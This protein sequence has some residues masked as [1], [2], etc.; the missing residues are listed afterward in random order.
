MLPIIIAVLSF[1]LGVLVYFLA[2]WPREKINDEILNLIVDRFLTRSFQAR[3]IAA[4][5]NQPSREIE[6]TLKLLERSGILKKRGKYYQTINPLFFLS[7]SYYTKSLR[8]SIDDEILY[9][10]AQNPFLTNY[11]LVTVYGLVPLTIIFAISV[12]LGIFPEITLFF[13]NYFSY[14]ELNS[15]L[16]FLILMSIVA[17][18]AIDNLIK[19]WAQDRNSVIVGVKSGLTYDIGYATE[20]SGRIR[21]PKLGEI[22]YEISMLQKF[23]NFFSEMPHGDIIIQV[24]GEKQPVTFEN[25][26]FPRELFYVL[27]QV[28]L[29]SL[30][31]RKRYART[32]MEWRANTLIPSVGT[33]GRRQ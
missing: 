30:E 29:K 7:E 5:K 15:L 32:M 2:T 31:W 17:V 8:F 1:L 16:A 13:T 26:P 23:L 33:G 10:G 4:I 22:S 3:D 11:Q 20:R 18:D 24:K 28:Q 14:L 27:R 9:A 19:S 21:R 6:P 25:M 12:T